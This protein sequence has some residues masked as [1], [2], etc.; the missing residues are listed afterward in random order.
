MLPH[1]RIAARVIRFAA[2]TALLGVRGESELKR[3]LEMTGG[4]SV[5]AGPFQGLKYIDTS[6][7]S[8]WAPK[9]LG[10]YECELHPIITS[11]ALESYRRIVDVGCAE[12]YYVAGLAYLARQQGVT[13]TVEGYDLDSS[14]VEAA[15]WLC[16]INALDARAH[17]CRYDLG[18]TSNDRSLFI[19]DIEGDEIHL[20][21]ADALGRLKASSFLVEVHD[22]PGTRR[23]IDALIELF[24]A[25][26]DVNIIDHRARVYADFPRRSVPAQPF[27]Q[28]RL[29][30]EYRNLG[31]TWIYATSKR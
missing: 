31:R 20:L 3:Y 12:G 14:A 25:T 16:R 13:L 7:G 21:N 19:V 9:V 29:M 26:H 2:R 11:I 24:R 18:G 15:N 30:N 17:C 4:V 8:A 10:S 1:I 6:H 27:E 28:L 23:N 22:P 5:L